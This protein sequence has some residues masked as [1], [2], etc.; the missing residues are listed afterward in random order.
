[1]TAGDIKIRS[2]EHNKFISGAVFNGANDDIQIN[3]VATLEAGSANLKGTI[4]AWICVPDITGT[5]SIF[6]LGDADADERLCL[7]I[8]A[9]CLQGINTDG[10]VAQ[11]SIIST[12]VVITAHKW[13]HVC[14]THNGIRPK[15][16]VDGAAVAMTDTVSTDLTEWCNG[17]TGLDKGTIG[18]N[19][20]KNVSEQDF[21]GG[22]AYVK[23]STGLATTQANW[24]PAQV[25]EEYDYRAGNGTGSGATSA[26]TVNCLWTLN[27]NAIE[28][29]TGGATYDGTIE[30]DVQYD[31][32]YSELTSKL[33][34]LGPVVADDIS[35][36]PYGLTGGVAA[37]VVKAA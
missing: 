24:L 13:H 28:T 20:Y 9:G 35:F 5:Y 10:G 8:A 34:L 27:G 18:M 6:C 7:Q 14:L 15:L 19:I 23:Y 12:S 29:V 3:A 22:I 4:S 25:K 32:E 11:W 30:S 33:R 17:L 1:M 37:V 16:Y 26:G 36:I 21:V 2:A 31:P